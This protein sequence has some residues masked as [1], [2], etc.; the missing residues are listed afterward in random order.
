MGK[1]GSYLRV[2]TWCVRLPTTGT[3]VSSV[4]L[5][6]ND[7]YSPC[8][9]GVP[10]QQTDTRVRTL[11]RYSLFVI[12]I[13]DSGKVRTEWKLRVEGQRVSKVELSSVSRQQ[14]DERPV[15]VTQPGHF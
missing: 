8:D 7:N 4:Q 12:S 6:F 3:G 1:Q 10:I 14:V 9:H 2:G 11:G 5:S 15:L 13:G